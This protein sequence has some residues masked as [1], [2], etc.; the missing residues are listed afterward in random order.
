VNYKTIKNSQKMANDLEELNKL[1]QEIRETQ[2]LLKNSDKNSIK[3]KGL[4]TQRNIL[5]VM[6]LILLAGFLWAFF[7]KD[8]G[9]FKNLE[10]LNNGEVVLINKDSLQYYKTFIDSLGAYR[11]FYI[12][13][14]KK[15]KYSK[16]TTQNSSTLNQEKVIYS[17][18]LKSVKN[19]KLA[20]DNLI[21]LKEFS[22]GEISKYSLGNFT[23]Y[24]EA[25][26]LRDHLKKVGFRDAFIVAESFGQRIGIRD[27]L[28]LSEE[29]EFL[30]RN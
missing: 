18:Q 29:P 2:E 27:A 25:K 16:N 17:V 13:T 8:K 6:S 5:A 7:L 12:E 14:K 28:N 11:T 15:E 22:T 9:R 30:E 23:K 20:S 26:E 19:K 1:E 10:R 24:A 21:N 4:I 3:L